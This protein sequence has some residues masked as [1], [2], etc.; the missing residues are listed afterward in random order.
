MSTTI[1]TGPINQSGHL[2][3]DFSNGI[4]PFFVNGGIISKE[5]KE[6]SGDYIE[7]D[8]EL[9]IEIPGAIEI[10]FAEFQTATG[11]KIA[12]EVTDLSGTTGKTLKIDPGSEAI[13]RVFIMYR[14]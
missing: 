13:V 8:D 5:L 4:S 6:A 10:T 9:I 7:A 12:H 11:V 2:V 3:A 1:K 14:V